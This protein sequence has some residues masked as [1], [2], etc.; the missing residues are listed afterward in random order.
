MELSLECWTE[1]R[2]I[3]NRQTERLNHLKS[4]P[5]QSKHFSTRSNT[6]NS[7]IIFATVEL[8]AYL[9][10]QLFMRWQWCWWHRDIG[11]LMM[12]IDFRCWWQNHYVGDFFRY[13][14]DFFNILIGHQHPES[15]TSITNLSPTHLA[16]TSVTKID[17]TLHDGKDRW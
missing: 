2:Q 8:K 6:I 14:G 7:K 9:Q 15:V 16:P 11:D 17:V 13:V 1:T 3:Q 5:F 10:T 4:H 12:V